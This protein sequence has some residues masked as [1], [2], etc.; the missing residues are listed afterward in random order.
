MSASITTPKAPTPKAPMAN[1]NRM[2]GKALVVEFVTTDISGDYRTFEFTEDFQTVDLTAG[3]DTAM[4]YG[5]TFTDGKASFSG[6]YNTADIDNVWTA[7]EKG[8]E[9]DLVWYPEGNEQGKPRYTVNAIVTSRGQNYP[10][11]GAI[12]LSI[13]FQFNGD[14]IEKDIVPT[15]P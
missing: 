15:S 4:C 5:T 7:T 3:P 14:T 1:C 9:G 10:Y 2:T 6:L 13:E 11:D 8:T 12:E